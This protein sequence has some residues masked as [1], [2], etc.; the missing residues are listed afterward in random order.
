MKRRAFV[1]GA[2]AVAGFS[3]MPWRLALAGHLDEG[4][5]KYGG[6]LRVAYASDIHS[7]RFTLN[8]EGPPGY[9]TYW[10][11][12]N[13]HNQLVTLGHDYEMVS[14]LAKS[15]EIRKD[16]QEYIFHL[17]EGV[18]FHDGTDCDAAAVK[19]NFDDMF[20]RGPKSWV[21]I[22]FTQV[23]STAVMDKQTFK[24]T[25][26]EPAALLPALAGYFSGVP[27]G[28][29]TAVEKYGD[30]WNRNPVGTGAFMY[31]IKDYR[32]DERILLKKN[33][34]YF[35][36]DKMG[37]ALPYL[38]SI[39]IRIIK[40]PIAG[41]TALRTGQIDFLQRIS[42]QH[43]PIMERAKGVKLDFKNKREIFRT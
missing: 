24:V 4:T 14:D 18:K 32:P 29:P 22:Y 8:R 9:E 17:H 34:N 21:H 23:D 30:D 20:T 38:D 39:E 5:P 15:W 37:K 6:T 33:P 3:A 2:A 19:W 42:A 27:I 43:V 40:D 35:K 1:A 31:D 25:M 28:S 13:V 11:S 16:G 7:G 36:K 12:N 26:K 41:M 10:V